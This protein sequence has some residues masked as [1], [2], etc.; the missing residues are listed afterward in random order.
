MAQIK[1]RQHR[2]LMLRFIAH[3]FIVNQRVRGILRSRAPARI[4]FPPWL[5]LLLLLLSSSLFADEQVNYSKHIKPV[6]IERC[7]ACHGVLKQEGGL[8]LDTA[9][10]AIKGGESGAAII[11]GDSGASLLLNRV[12][13]T[14][15]SERMPPE[16]E[17]LKPDQIAALRNWIAH[18]AEAPADEQPSAIRAITGPSGLPCGSRCRGLKCRRLSKLAG[19]TIQSPDSSPVSIAGTDLWYN[20]KRTGESGC[21]AFRST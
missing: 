19:N 16:G 2:S 12:T 18:K 8:R 13:A 9:V 11:P 10:L 17:P 14:D 3:R 1:G 21:D 6:L 4:V 7:V 20:L 5:G 15:A